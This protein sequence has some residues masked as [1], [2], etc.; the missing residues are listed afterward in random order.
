MNSPLDNI[1]RRQTRIFTTFREKKKRRCQR[2]NNVHICV[3]E[4]LPLLP[5][6]RHFAT[7]R[8]TRVAR[9]VCPIRIEKFLSIDIHRKMRGSVRSYLQVVSTVRVVL[10]D[11]FSRSRRSSALLPLP[12]FLLGPEPSLLRHTNRRYH[13]SRRAP[14]GNVISIRSPAVV[15][16]STSATTDCWRA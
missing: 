1:S 3:D 9:W 12:C 10:T 6:R 11:R 15:G 16:L 13:D 14:W 8:T 7:S 4:I 2:V 5:L